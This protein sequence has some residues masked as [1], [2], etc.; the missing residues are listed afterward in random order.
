[1]AELLKKVQIGQVHGPCEAFS[2]VPDTGADAEGLALPQTP[3]E[4][5]DLGL[6]RVHTGQLHSGGSWGV[7]GAGCGVDAGGLVG[8]ASGDLSTSISAS[9]SSGKM[10]KGFIT[11]FGGSTRGP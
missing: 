1:M 7:E 4:G 11:F 2:G 8:V 6:I 10:S 5:A 3:Q 9:G